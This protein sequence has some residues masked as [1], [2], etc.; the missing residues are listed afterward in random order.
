M[1]VTAGGVATRREQTRRRLVEATEVLLTERS[2]AE[3]TVEDVMASAGLTRTA[4]YRYFPHLEALLLES[5]REIVGE[6]HA[7]AA[8][9]LEASGDLEEGLVDAAAGL[10]EV[11]ARHGRVL[12]AVNEAAVAGERVRAAWHSAIDAFV[13]PVTARIE[14]LSGG[15][16]PH[17][18]ETARALVWMIERYLL[19]TYGRGR[20]VP[21]SV[22]ATVL[23]DIWRPVLAAVAAAPAGAAG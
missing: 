23:A 15:R 3:I 21:T 12:L 6:V 5:V 16:A 14:E 11:W 20:G 7:A 8:R 10:A 13:E 19:E 18:L 1:P 9:W 22:A 2:F 17:A 4:F